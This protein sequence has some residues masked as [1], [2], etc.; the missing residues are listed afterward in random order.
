MNIHILS[1][2]PQLLSF[3]LIAPFLLRLVIGIYGLVAGW[4]R[5]H[6]TYKW[7]SVLYF[8]ISTFLILGLYTQ[9]AALAGFIL[10]IFDYFVDAKTIPMTMEQK[11]FRKLCAIIL[12][13]LIFTG[14]GFFAI[15]LPL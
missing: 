4:S 5:Y 15:D 8:V 2:F 1:L 10:V 11:M 12:L 7:T 3:S 9:G 6:K 13:S 14:P